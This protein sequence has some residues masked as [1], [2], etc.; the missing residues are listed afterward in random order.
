MKHS[1]LIL[2][3]PLMVAIISCAGGNAALK[4]PDPLEP[5]RK[6]LHRGITQYQK[7]CYHNA[8][9]HLLRAHEQFTAYDNLT[10]IAMSLNN[11]GNVYGK[12]GDPESA[13]LFFESSRAIYRDLDDINGAVQTLSNKA[14]VLIKIDKFLLVDDWQAIIRSY[15]VYFG[16]LLCGKV[17]KHHLKKCVAAVFCQQVHLF[18]RA[19]AANEM[20]WYRSRDN[21]P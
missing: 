13:I 20:F 19:I 12:L 10:G 1:W 3:V 5:A 6:E 4:A 18:Q 9:P 17:E 2:A 11:I 21:P 7:G 8:L 14:A 16:V 15:D